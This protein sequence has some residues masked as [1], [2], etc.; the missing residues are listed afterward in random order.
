VPSVPTPG[1]CQFLPRCRITL[2]RALRLHA[3]RTAAG[4]WWRKLAHFVLGCTGMLR[5]SV[6]AVGLALGGCV[7]GGGVDL[8]ST[9]ETDGGLSGGNGA[10]ASDGGPETPGDQGSPGAGSGGAP[11]CE[12][13]DLGG[14]SGAFGGGEP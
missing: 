5:W 3:S 10:S 12:P 4:A 1:T 13:S 11:C 9:H 7:L 14:A 8:P 2:T 6:V